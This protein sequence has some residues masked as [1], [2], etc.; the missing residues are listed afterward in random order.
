[1]IDE[2]TKNEIVTAAHNTTIAEMRATIASVPAGDVAAIAALRKSMRTPSV[3]ARLAG[4]L[5]L[6]FQGT[7]PDWVWPVRS[8]ATEVAAGTD[9]DAVAWLTAW[10]SR[11]CALG[12]EQAMQRAWHEAFAR[13]H[14]IDNGYVT[15]AVSDGLAVSSVVDTD[16]ECPLSFPG[17][18]G[19]V[20]G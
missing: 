16:F 18:G 11:R 15:S 10:V 12:L 8:V 1:L 13:Y 14:P 5:G 9:S 7:R 4:N 20:R 17:E 19:G 3:F 6:T 2:Q